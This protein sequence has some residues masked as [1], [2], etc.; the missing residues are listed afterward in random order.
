VLDAATGTGDLA[1][2]LAR[3]GATVVG[4]DFCGPMMALA[5]AKVTAAG[6]DE[7]IR[8][9]EG[10]LLSLPFA[11]STF[12]AVASAF[13]LR[14]VAS[15]PDALAEM[16]RVVAPGGR[17]VILEL[18]RPHQPVFRTL[19]RLYLHL[20]VPL[21]GGLATGQP[22]AYVYLPDSIDR[23]LSLDELHETME[24]VGLRAVYC[25]QLTLGTVAV[26]VGV[27]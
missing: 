21:V 8:F 25:T 22:E 27:K 18:T 10:D 20:L 3:H 16:R 5:R 13:A 19:S 14:N 6:F 4:V 9:V 26:H 11:D 7:R 12:A 23:F 2:A 1:L 24:Q 15:I 17:V